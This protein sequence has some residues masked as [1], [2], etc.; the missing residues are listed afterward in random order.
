MFSQNQLAPQPVLADQQHRALVAFSIALIRLPACEN[1]P[2]I[3]KVS[4]QLLVKQGVLIKWNIFSFT[5]FDYALLHSLSA[6]NN[7]DNL[8][9]HRY[10]ILIT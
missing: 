6:A 8:V 10:T 5:A 9:V 2:R 3:V 1:L 7:S 4:S